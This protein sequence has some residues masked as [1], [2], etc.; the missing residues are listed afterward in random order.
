L[1]GHHIDRAKEIRDEWR[2]NTP[3]K[4]REVD[5]ALVVFLSKDEYGIH[6]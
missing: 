1:R 6:F 3:E 5:P 4:M 2:P